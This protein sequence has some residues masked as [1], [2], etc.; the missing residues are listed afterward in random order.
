MPTPTEFDLISAFSAELLSQAGI[1]PES[2]PEYKRVQELLMER[3]IARLFLE[4]IVSLPPDVAEQV[5]NDL[6]Q[7]KPDPANTMRILS[8][9]VPD[10]G[11]R[12][13]QTLTRLHGELLS[14]LKKI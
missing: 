1:K 4:I 14:D 5:A 7:S 12:I 2:S 9:K 3:V 10:L 11:L 13:A 6:K 8:A